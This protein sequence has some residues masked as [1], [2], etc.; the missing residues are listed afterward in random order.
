[1]A[2]LSSIGGGIRRAPRP[3]AT[4]IPPNLAPGL[5]MPA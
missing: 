2:A 1:M 5:R 3:G 4:A